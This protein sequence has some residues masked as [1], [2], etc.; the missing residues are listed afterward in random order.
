MNRHRLWGLARTYWFDALIVAAIG[1]EIA[2]VV[3]S[4]GTEDGPSGP[5][6]FDV[7]FALGSTVPLF[8]RRRFPFGAPA[9]VGV[10]FA[11]GSFVDDR[12]TPSGLV[13]VLTAFAVFVLF[14]L[15]RN[16]T[17]AIAGL[18]LGI[19]VT[20]IISHNDPKGSVGNFTFT[21]IAFTIA[22][23]IGFALGRKFN[24]AEEAKERARPR[25]A[26]AGG[27][28]AARRRGRAYADRA[29]AAR[30]RRSQCQRHDRPGLGGTPPAPA[31][32]GEGA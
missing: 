12:V 26:G 31:T 14:G 8:A 19:G 2:W 15:I 1:L 17:Q 16:R 28:G 32:S 5:L 18:A 24:E 20:A 27:A 23:A 21:S 29:R 9:T 11:A 13:P 25:R 3:V 7:L 4:R 10:V 22:W 6:W 30:R